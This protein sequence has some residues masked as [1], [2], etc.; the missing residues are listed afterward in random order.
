MS[1]VGFISLGCAKNLVDTEVMLAKLAMAGYEITPECEDSDV[2]IINTCA[3]IESAKQES[4]ETIIDIGWLKEHHK[5]KGIVVCGCMAERYGEQIK[6]ELPEVDCIVGLGSIDEIVEAVKKAENGERFYTFKDKEQSELGGDRIVTTGTTAYL[7]VAEGCDNRCTYCA[8]PLIRGKMRSRPIEDIVKEAKD[9]EA[10]GVKE[11]CIVAQDTSRYGLDLY[12]EY[13][14][15]EL[16]REITK[17]TQIPWLRLLYLYPDK[18]TDEL[19]EEMR[20]NPRVVKYADI[21]VQ[22]IS[23]NVLKR[24]GRHGGSAI[25]KDAIKRLRTIEGI[26]LRTTVMVGFPGETEEDFLELC[27]FVKE[28]KF[29]R[30]GAFT[31]S[32]EEDTE[33]ATF[34]G[35]IDEQTKQDR[36]D[37]I[38]Q[39]QLDISAARNRKL[40]GRK[41]RVLCESYDIPAEVFVGRSE[42]DAPDVDG[43][44]FFVSEKKVNEGQFVT[45]KITEAEDYD[46]IGEVCR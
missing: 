40:I 10:L 14:L 26:T 23:D 25:I 44:V 38:M 1:K 35:E 17:N 11:L 15:A 9:L 36:Y 43:K 28:T 12:G 30:L 22:H 19:V 20:T 41:M 33:A 21:P 42:A 2:V 46:L 16:V 3:F 37:T 39:I 6:K 13:K 7:K 4:I 45:V 31:Y 27:E 5:L 8:I 32:P 24:M 34:D 18:I 29:D